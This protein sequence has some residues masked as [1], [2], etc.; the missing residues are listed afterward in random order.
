MAKDMAGKEENGAMKRIAAFIVDKRNLFFLLYVVALVFS[1]FSMNWV[2]VENDITTYL[3]E[4]TETRRGLTVM[5]ENFVSF[6]SARVM[7]S[8]ITPSRARELADRV[9]EIQGV[10]QVTFDSS[11]NHYRSGS[12]LLD[13][14]FDAE[15][16]DPRTEEA[17]A[18]I[19]TLL[20]GYDVYVDTT[21]GVDVSA[22]L[23]GEMTQIVLVAAVII[24]VVLILTSKAYMEVP[25]LL[26][27]FIA[28]ALLN[29]GTNYL[30]GKISFISNAI[31]VVL[32]LALAIDYAIILCHRF[33]AEHETLPSREACVEALSKSIPEICSSSL[34][35]IS[36]LGALAFM[37]FG[38]GLD[39]AVVLIKAILL[40][41]L[42]V[43]T[44]MPGLLM[45]F[46]K[47]IDKTQ[48]KNLIPPITAVGKFDVATR[49]VVPPL[50]LVVVVF[51][52]Y[53]ANRCP[54]AYSYNNLDTAKQSKQQMAVQKI[55]ETFGSSN[56]VAIMVPA[57]DYEKEKRILET[58][59][60]NPNVESTVGLAGIEAMDG[61][62]LTDA[63]TPRQ[64]SELAGLD[65]EVCKLLYTAYA[66]DKSQY[67]EL[68]NG[69][70]AYQVPLFDMFLFLKEQMETG[71]IRLEGETQQ[72]LDSL[73][74]QLDQARLQ[75]QSDRYS[76]MVVNLNLPEEGEETVLMM[77]EIHNLVRSQYGDDFYLMGNS[78]SAMD[79]SAS[80]VQDN[81]LISIL[82]ALFVMLILLVTFQ[83]AGLPV[84]L[85]LVI[86]GSIWIN[87]AIPAIR[88]TPLYFLGYLIVNAIQMGANI[89]YAIVISSHYT[90]QKRFCQPKEAIVRA[91]NA[92][93]ATVFTSGTIMASAGNLIAVMTANPVISTFGACIGRG[94]IISLILVM[95]VLP[96]LLVLGDILIERTSFRMPQLDRRT[97]SVSGT[98]RVRGRVRGYISGMVDAE[99]NGEVTGQINASVS[100]GNL[101]IVGEDPAAEGGS[102]A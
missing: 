38:I 71:N 36:G 93:F 60:K 17:M 42:T 99:I 24:V 95:G 89:D 33:S 65:Y 77:D 87:F 31:T 50:F 25:V 86:Q 30:C 37:H 58:L 67:G 41:L 68:L 101:E 83:S 70:G 62:I 45:L 7:I 21:V 59:E 88:N 96:Q 91:L 100:A 1:L 10:S 32:Q 18:A 14:N 61:Y 6:G 76:R 27:T 53:F 52:F 29:M 54:Y 26:I 98:V 5:N 80:F 34:T 12:A 47:L 39:M 97:R 64:F 51:A 40:S 90:E 79:L 43:F 2:Q 28:A 16:T 57:G 102:D 4:D 78:T 44:L 92:S 72:T 74:R 55:N 20:D 84:L 75:L 8:N 13:V 63:L 19:R 85:I 46:S 94:T 23:T 69:V 73:F 48:H 22:E 15:A 56:M 3:P 9:G 82:S 11:G 81:L 35:T 49:Y 66:T